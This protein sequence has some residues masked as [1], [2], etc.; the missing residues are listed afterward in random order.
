MWDFGNTGM[1]SGSSLEQCGQASST[2]GLCSEEEEFS[3]QIFYPS[4][5]LRLNMK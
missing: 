4:I 3:K 2:F 1:D 5:V